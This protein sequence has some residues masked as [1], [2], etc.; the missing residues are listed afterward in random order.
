MTLWAGVYARDS[1]RPPSPALVHDLKGALSRR[2]GEDI[3][4]VRFDRAVV[5]YAETGAFSTPSTH[6]DELALTIVAGDPLTA[7]RPAVSDRDVDIARLHDAWSRGDFAATAETSGTFAALHYDAR[8]GSLSIIAD[9]LGVRPIYFAITDEVVVVANALRMIEAMPSLPKALDVRGAV[10]TLALGYPLADRTPYRD[11]FAI[12]DGEV[13]T[14]RDRAVT[15]RH[16]W[17]ITSIAEDPAPLDE[18]ARKTHAAFATAVDR[19]LGGDRRGIAFL[20]GGLDSRC[21][22]AELVARGVELHTF[23]FANEGT[24]DQILGDEFAA[25]AKTIHSRTPRPPDPVRWSLTM[26]ERWAASTHRARL[27]VERPG[28]VWSGDGGSVGYGFVGVYPSVIALLRAGRR[29][30]AVDRYCAEHEISLPLRVFRPAVARE[31]RDVL[32]VGLR[33]SFD[34][35]RSSGD[36]GRELYVFRMQ[37][38]QRRHLTLHFEDVDLHR[39]EFHLPFYD[40]DLIGAVAAAPADYGVGHRLYN[41]ALRH[42]PGIVSAVPW[43]TYPGHEPCPVPLPSEAIDQW[44]DRQ[45]DIVR[46]GRRAGILGETARLLSGRT[47]PTPLLDRR[48]LVAAG[49][50]HW[51]GRGDYAYVMDYAASFSEYWRVSDGRWRLDVPHRDAARSGRVAGDVKT[52]QRS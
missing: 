36:P 29:D 1:H 30:E 44:G 14:F 27:P 52:A 13:V 5:A 37:H 20:S 42:F 40:A 38:D 28:M 2:P 50:M 43:Q 4:L 33:E 8:T 18:A 51:M 26:A 6:R 11:V 19:R 32:H 17:R 10:E 24:K 22:V 34:E 39:L 3:Q 46:R 16:Y 49:L 41:A 23:N 47:F 21:L 9:K 7:G 25:V 35:A 12:R 31:L 48:Y 45:K 15:R